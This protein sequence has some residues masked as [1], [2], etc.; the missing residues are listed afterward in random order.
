[1]LTFCLI[2]L[3]WDRKIHCWPIIEIMFGIVWLLG[4]L[5]WLNMVSPSVFI[6]FAWFNLQ[7]IYCWSIIRKYLQVFS[8]VYRSKKSKRL[9]QSVFLLNQV[10]LTC[11]S[12]CSLG[13]LLCAD[14]G[15]LYL[16][17]KLS[18]TLYLAQFLSDL[19][20]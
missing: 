1:M 18:K 15:C 17:A 12:I 10:D 19:F 2:S 8:I 11:K 5:S 20:Y 7:I 14:K 16:F 9:S 6:Q 3:T 4:L 13:T